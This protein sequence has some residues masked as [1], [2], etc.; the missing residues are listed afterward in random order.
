[1]LV[2]L[3]ALPAW[4]TPMAAEEEHTDFSSGIAVPSQVNVRPPESGMTTFFAA[5]ICALMPAAVTGCVEPFMMAL[6]VCTGVTPSAWL[7][8]TLGFG[9][10]FGS[11]FFIMKAYCARSALDEAVA[12]VM[13]DPVSVLSRVGELRMLES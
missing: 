11:Y 12:V 8:L 3:P 13:Y 6:R 7:L 10:A 9:L 2:S 1:M 4:T 5:A